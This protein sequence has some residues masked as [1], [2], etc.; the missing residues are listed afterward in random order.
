[1][2]NIETI[3]VGLMGPAIAVWLSK[4]KDRKDA[5]KAEL[6]A[7]VQ[8]ALLDERLKHVQSEI[9]TAISDSR[10]KLIEQLQNGL[11]ARI[12]QPVMVRLDELEKRLDRADL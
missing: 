10:G 12:I 6:S 3:V 4:Q 1:M 9:G 5:A 8:V 7:A 2:V 11:G